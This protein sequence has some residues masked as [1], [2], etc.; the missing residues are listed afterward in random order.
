M[1]TESDFENGGSSD[2][3]DYWLDSPVA[4]AGETNLSSI[5][6][7]ELIRNE[8]P[9]TQEDSGSNSGSNVL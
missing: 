6:E 9:I 7:R 4:K 5:D 8:T 1:N 3:H 2:I